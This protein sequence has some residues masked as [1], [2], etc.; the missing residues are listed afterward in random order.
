MDTQPGGIELFLMRIGDSERDDVATL[1][2]QH[3]LGRLSVEEFDRRQR[4]AL[5]A[6]T[7]ADLAAQVADLPA[8]H[9]RASAP[10]AKRLHWSDA[11]KARAAAIWAC[12]P[13][14][15]V[16]SSTVFATYDY[17]GLSSPAA[18]FWGSAVTGLVGFAAGGVV[19][20]MRRR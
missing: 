12:V 5:A 9:G 17:E 1:T 10:A 20:R 11:G 3:I 13:A 7:A 18:I 16:T 19:S 4:A 8:L 6:V 15:I 2:E 14:A